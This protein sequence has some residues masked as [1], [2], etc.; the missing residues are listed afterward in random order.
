MFFRFVD[1]S[2]T[3]AEIRDALLDIASANGE[4]LSKARAHNLATNFKKG[5]YDP[6]LMRI[7]GYSDPVGEEAVACADA[8]QPWHK[9]CHN[10]EAAN[11][12]VAA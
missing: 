3:K 10:C 4:P 8:G 12:Q 7:I 1:K 11:E 6:D 5:H 2:A 9:L